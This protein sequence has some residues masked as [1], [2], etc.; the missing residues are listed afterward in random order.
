MAVQ[1]P[2]GAGPGTVLQVM[3][4]TGLTI[5]ATVPEGYSPGQQF[6]VAYPAQG[7]P[8]GAIPSDMEMEAY[9]PLPDKRYDVTNLTESIILCMMLPCCVGW[10]TKTLL[11]GDQEVTLKTKHL[12][13][14][15]TQKRPY[16][17]LGS[18]EKR[19]QCAGMCWTIASDL[20][21]VNEK[22]E[23]GIQ[24]GCCGCDEPLI[25]EIVNEMQQ[26][27][28][29][30]GNVA[31]IQKLE[32]LYNKLVDVAT[33]LPL[34]L[35]SYGVR[36][37][38]RTSP[39]PEPPKVFQDKFFDVTNTFEAIC[40]CT[41]KQ[42]TLTQEE[43]VLVTNK[44]CGLAEQITQRREYAQLG[45]VKNAKHCICCRVS[46]T[47]VDTFNPQCGCAHG[48]V[49]DLT[50][51]LQDRMIMRGNMGQIRKQEKMM[52]QVTEL[53]IE[54]PMLMDKIGAQ[55]PPGQH[56]MSQLY[57][58][59]QPN[60]QDLMKVDIPTLQAGAQAVPDRTFDVTDYWE[61]CCTCLCTCGIA[62]WTKTSVEL[63]DDEM[64]Y[65]Q[66]N[67]IDDMRMRM[68]YAQMDSVDFTRACC[69]FY[70]VNEMNPGCGCD[71]AKVE[72]LSAELQSRKEKRAE[73]AQVK[74]L[75]L[76]HSM[77]NELSVKS[78][79]VLHTL[80]IQYPP[81]QDVMG[82][83][84]GSLI[85]RSIDKK[86]PPHIDP[87]V[88]FDQKTY[89]IT[90]LWESLF[91]CCCSLGLCGW[92][93]RTMELSAEEMT[94]TTEN[95]CLYNKARTPYAK[96]G[97]VEVEEYCCCCHGLPEVASPGWGCEKAKVDQ[98]ASDLQ[99]RKVKRGNIAQLMMQ[100]NMVQETTKLNAKTRVLLD[101]KKVQYPP[102]Q[103]EMNRV[104][105]SAPPAAGGPTV[106]NA[107]QQVGKSY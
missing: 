76:M 11:V 99:E 43:A 66:K 72:D 36:Y 94:I 49:A 8:P 101:H 9:Q 42:L 52:K 24:P 14:V 10:M 51:E 18:V 46:Q 56:T 71:K 45:S 40:G 96:L 100:E 54:M 3:T 79:V 97:A 50:Q 58:S 69:C 6:Q 20:A 74:Q 15:N 78:D 86:D 107:P 17:Q 32:F 98:I 70:V 104:F 31:Q 38:P 55:Y 91:T 53:A 67:N 95:C 41:T 77:L 90:D 27:K 81:R 83:I 35:D 92:T 34:L 2:P 73:I 105:G 60:I 59:K 64:I 1:V 63:K 22:G 44:C 84:F 33:Q 28:L 61:S 19:S 87:A 47:D 5:Q 68:P 48:L 85:P 25:N 39:V 57:G 30:R 37:M 4:P 21:P 16:A 102:S 75:E 7:P 82:R 29:K 103:Q 88:K 13:G 12:C 23:G 106:V 62:G 93:R 89:D 80:G 65:L 26:R